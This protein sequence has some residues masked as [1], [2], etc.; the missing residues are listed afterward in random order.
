MT[1]SG[2]GLVA[3]LAVTQTVGYGVL[4][5]AFAVVLHPVAADLGTSVTVVT[6]ALTLAVLI[7]GV[8]AIPVGRWLDRHGGRGLMTA[9]SVLGTVAVAAWSAVHTAP[10]LYAVFAAI[11][12][13]SAM[14]LYEPAFAVLVAVLD[15]ARRA[16]ALLAVTIVAG[17][18]SSIF[19]PLTGILVDRYGWRTAVLVLAVLQAATIP[20]HAGLRNARAPAVRPRRPRLAALRDPGFWLLTAGFVVHGGALAAVAVHLVSYLV[21]LGHP[22]TLAAAVTGLLGV[23]SVTGRVVATGLSRRLLVTTVTAAVFML[24][25]LAIAALPLLGRSTLGAVCCVAGF[26]LGFGVGTIARPAI[27]ADRYGRTGYATVAGTLAAPATV[28]KAG[29]PLAAAALAAVAGYPAVMLVV[30][31]ACLVAAGCLLTVR[32]PVEA[33]RRRAVGTVG[34]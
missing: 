19:I 4:Y 34:A 29:A 10:Q 26:G 13:A 11:G 24:Q 3:A 27:L 8:A 28:S 18:A 14:V 20:L 31:A 30:A 32:P 17:F 12:I 16:K 33:V 22:P 6:G 9:G 1:G 2:R 23:L 5:Y 15:P 21:A 7:T 25:G